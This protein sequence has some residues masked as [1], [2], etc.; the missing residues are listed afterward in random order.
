MEVR[1]RR[2]SGRSNPPYHLPRFD[3][4]AGANQ[5]LRRVGIKGA[6]AIGVFEDHGVS[7]SAERSGKN[8][9]ARTRCI[10][11]RSCRCSDVDTLMKLCIAGKGIRAEPVVR[12]EAPLH[13]N[14]HG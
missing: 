4:V 11:R 7:V 3:G 10:D 2:V 1:T 8:Y 13:G 9:S 12:R 14:R 5:D 6:P